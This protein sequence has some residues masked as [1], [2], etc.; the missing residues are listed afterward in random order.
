MSDKLKD[1]LLSEE[2]SEYKFERLSARERQIPEDIHS[3]EIKQTETLDPLNRSV[4]P[5]QNPR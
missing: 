5:E 3:H 4:E 1:R 2:S